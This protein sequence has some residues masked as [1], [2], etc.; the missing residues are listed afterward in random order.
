MCVDA[1]SGKLITIDVSD[2]SNQF[3]RISAVNNLILSACVMYFISVVIYSIVVF[4]Y[5][6]LYKI[7]ASVLVII[8]MLWCIGL[9]AAFAGWIAWKNLDV[10]HTIIDR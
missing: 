10:L 1:N 2:V 8:L 7:D 4:T 5:F 6:L 3:A 9:P